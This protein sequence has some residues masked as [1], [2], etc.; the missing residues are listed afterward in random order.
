MK[1]LY[2]I[3]VLFLGVFLIHS[4]NKDEISTTITDIDGNVYQTVTIGTQVW[5]AENLKTTKYNDGTAI[6]LVTNNAAWTNLT[7]PGYCWYNND[8]ANK[9]IYGAMYNGFTVQTSKLCPTGW[10]VPAEDEFLILQRYLI[11]NG[12]NYDGTTTENK[13]AKSMAATTRWASSTYTGTPGNVLSSNN[14]C[15]FSGLPGGI[16]VYSGIYYYIEN[17]G[18]CWSTRTESSNFGY[19]FSLNYATVGLIESS[20]PR[21]SGISV[22]C[23]KD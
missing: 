7:T 19:F 21:R 10:H 15:G 13:I 23:L 1:K 9:N 8:A 17:E 22:R 5:M 16:R 6:P 4:C 2:S 14:S 18:Y 12:Y 11:A 20:G 3:L